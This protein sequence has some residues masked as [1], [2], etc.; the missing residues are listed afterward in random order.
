MTFT[1]GGRF[2]RARL[3]PPRSP[4]PLTVGSQDSCCS[5]RSRRLTLQPFEL[6]C[7]NERLLNLF[8]KRLDFDS[9]NPVMKLTHTV[10]TS[11]LLIFQTFHKVISS[12][13]PLL[14]H[15]PVIYCSFY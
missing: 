12:I 14:F 8:V 2:P 9:R 4:K 15:V 10:K 6:V 5:R 11:L 1:A 7:R 3:E 13:I